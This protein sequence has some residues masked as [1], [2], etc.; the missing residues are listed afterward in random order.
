MTNTKF[1]KKTGMYIDW[2]QIDK[3]PEIDIFIDIGI[4]PKGTPLFWEKYNDKKLICIDPLPEALD[5]T[6][7]LL[8]GVDYKFINCALGS[9]K[10]KKTLNVEANKGRSSFLK[11]TKINTEDPNITKLSVDVETLDRVIE[12][13][14]SEERVGIK[15]DTEGYELEILKGALE[16]LKN[17][18]FVIAEVRHNHQSFEHQ[19]GF[20]EFNLFMFQ[21]G[22]V[23]S[24]IFTA[25]PF[26]SDIAY[27]PF[28]KEI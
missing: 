18:S 7:K 19:Y 5:I 3:L 14:I 6:S 15:I 10:S 16:T 17:T 28:P 9:K 21:C 13:V 12:G 23:P 26:I 4:G 22:F 8:S 1:Y 20:D 24:M 2:E 11:T 27:F 25:K